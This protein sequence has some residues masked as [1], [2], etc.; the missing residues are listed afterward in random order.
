VAV[1]L[2]LFQLQQPGGWPEIA[3]ILTENKALHFAPA[4]G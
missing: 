1:Y 2:H 3:E 4:G